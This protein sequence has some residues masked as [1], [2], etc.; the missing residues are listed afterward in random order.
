MATYPRTYADLKASIN[1]RIHNKMGLVAT[2]RVLINDA[3]TEVNNLKL[4]STKRS[5]PLTP[6][7][8]NDIYQY[9]APS[10]LKG[11]NIIGIQ[12]Q[13]MNRSRHRIW[14]L[15]T[16]EEFDI[17][18]QTSDCLIA[19]AD[20]TFLRTILVSAQQ[21]GLRQATLA[22]LQGT[23]G[24]S[25]TNAS[26][27]AF[28]NASNLA[29]DTYNFIK[30]SGS[31][32]FD[33][34]AGGT[35]AGIELGSVNTFDLTSY[36]SGSSAFTWLYMNTASLATNVKI[37]LGSSAT[38]YYEMTAT[39]ANGGAF[40][41]GWNLIRFDFNNK[42]T[43][44]TPVDSSCDYIAIF[45]TKLN[46][47]ADTSWRLNSLEVKQGEISNL[48]YYSSKPWQSS[49]GTLLDKSTADDDYIVCDEDEWNLFV[50]KGVEVLGLAA[51]EYN[52]S[53]MATRRYGDAQAGVGLAGEYKRNYPTES[54]NLTST[55]YYI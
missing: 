34:T 40:S 37:R 15:V 46:A 28:G 43:T 53:Q 52:D 55:Y 9:T 20:H 30:G 3:V 47:S 16:E 26:W 13:S 38:D 8:F 50:E 1:A 29:T 17:R 32:Q 54:L 14:E 31:L 33:L 4:R 35:T 25:S 27:T 2:P 41:N 7:L 49:A 45:I 12:P 48:I 39:S 10:D 6:N 36:K 11:N 18:K 24:D 44:G 22:S 42:T 5:A 23:S 21:E 51:R 19:V